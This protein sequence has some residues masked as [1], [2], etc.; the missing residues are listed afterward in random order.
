[1]EIGSTENKVI[2]FE[3]E[4]K[5]LNKVLSEIK[6]E[7]VL[8]AEIGNKLKKFE[9]IIA[10]LKESVRD[11]ILISEAS[12]DV[13]FRI[14]LTGKLI[15]I[16]PSCEE[17][18]GYE[19]DDVLG[20]SFIQFIS[21]ENTK[22]VIEAL[23]KFFK[24]KKLRNFIT[25]VNHKNGEEIPVEINA[26]II[27]IN[28]KM[29]GQGTIHLIKERVKSENKLRASENTFRAVWERSSD[30][31]RLTDETGVV[32]MCNQAYSKMVGMSKEEIEGKLFSV[33]YDQA[34]A[35]VALKNYQ[36]SIQ[37]GNIHSKYESTVNLWNGAQ[38]D[39]EISN[40]FLE[41]INNKRYLLSIFRDITDRKSSEYLLRKKDDLL[42]GIAE[43]TRSLISNRDINTGFNSALRIL[44]I[45]A[46]VDRVYIYKHE[47]IEETEELYAKLLFEWSA[48]SA[49][50]QIEDPALQ[51]LSYSRFATLNFYENFSKG[52]SLKFITK[53]LPSHAQSA[54]IDK[55]IKSLILVPIMV[56]DQYWGFVGF[57]DLTK[58]RLWT[59]NEESLLFTMSATI[60]AVIKNNNISSDLREKNKEL[61]IAL[62]RAESAVKAKSEFL[63]L[64]SHEI[65]T[66]MNGVIGMTGLLLDTNLNEDQREYVETIRLSGDQLLV[67][68]NDILD[69][70]KIE[71]EKLE[72]EHQPFDLRDCIEDS[73]DL[74]APRAA[75]KSLDLA[76][77]IGDNSPLT[78]IGDVTRLRQIIINLVNNSVKFTEEGEVFV[79]VSAK[80]VDDKYE[81]LFSVKDTG[82]GIAAD[83]MDRLF[84]SFSQV[85]SSTTRTHGGTG[86]GLA[87]SQR[88]SQMMGGKVWVESEV[89]KG[90]TFH[91]TILVESAPSKSKLYLRGDQPELKNKKV[92][93]VDDN[94]TN[95]RIIQ[96]Q[97]ESWG[98]ESKIVESGEKALKLFEKGEKFDIALFDYQMPYMDGIS[99][100]HEVRKYENAKDIPIIILT[101]IGRKEQLT[102]FDRMNLAGF[103]SKPV[104]HAQLQETLINV[105]NGK[106][107]GK[108]DKFRREVSIDKKLAEQM[109][110][111]ILLAEDN[112]VNQRVALRIL[113]KLGYRAD[114]A[115]T[116]IEAV[117]AVRNI[118]YDI[119]FM[120]VLMPEMDGFEA[121]KVILD[122][123]QPDD[124]PK[125]IA[126]T[127]NAMQGDRES[128]L[129]AGMDDYL[130]KPIRI[131]DLQVIISKWGK[132]IYDEKDELIS[133]LKSKSTH[134]SL[135]D[136][137][138][139]TFL[140][141]I[142]SEQDLKF[143]IE[144]LDIYITSLPTMI[145]NI[146]IAVDEKN[147]K[148]LQINAHKLKGS[149]VTL[150]I[151]LVTNLS[152]NLEKAAKENRFNDY[153]YKMVDDLVHKFETIIKE[154]DVIREKYSKY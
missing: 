143:Y 147:S 118:N 56:D 37:K 140:Q 13:I 134:T 138:K 52:N 39:F 102:D 66:P 7:G 136:E 89:G 48:E 23:K 50:A 154:L 85:D 17:A 77:L 105:L 51:K 88:L 142:Q 45:A 114:V 29:L 76:Y 15:F 141:D 127:A 80:K 68:I 38:L 35:S 132:K 91:F 43:A 97:T 72:L 42:Q 25:A 79:S 139:I 1:M 153:T 33:V 6:A 18:F 81:L 95:R 32:F 124:R 3:Q 122:E 60:A 59:D 21:K 103:I 62:A 94:Q 40:S 146:K 104:K 109:P 69:F 123:F 113:E 135:I 128:C 106:D 30:G 116:G 44:G 101:S 41:E 57:D 100:S 111:R 145:S 82:M 99:L 11:Y 151:D 67:I 47:I 8:P 78:I 20:K 149:S 63:A 26:K 12:I 31:M 121:T 144:L 107:K 83:K 34:F 4:L 119:V 55:S 22:S 90:S 24:E 98:M 46:N 126:M 27:E 53:D 65:R 92:L 108:K 9:E 75:E 87:I 36:L 112:A 14:S 129:E 150:G 71:S 2:H 130:S 110:L 131:E 86:L 115:A 10:N 70:S 117:G 152:H 125:I 93:I 28:G 133:E 58:D 74:V 54:F 5:E 49:T 16:T 120:D 84:K 96:L 19:I 64:M 73:L 61:D 148:M 137:S